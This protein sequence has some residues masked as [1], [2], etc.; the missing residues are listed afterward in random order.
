MTG[1]AGSIGRAVVEAYLDAG[2]RVGVL[3]RDAGRLETLRRRTGP[4]L[5]ATV[6]SVEERADHQ[7][8][9]GAVLER[10][11]RLDVFV[12]NSTCSSVMQSWAPATGGPPRRRS[13]G[14]EA[15][16]DEI[17][18][19]AR[20]EVTACRLPEVGSEVLAHLVQ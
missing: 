20:R 18:A 3:A 16:V 4:D 8:A 1:G 2:A 11:G 13:T 14:L 19:I 12:G 17:D 7:R 5:I 9:G 10:F 6:G 15:A